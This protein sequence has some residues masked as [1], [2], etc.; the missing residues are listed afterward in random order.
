MTEVKIPYWLDE[1]EILF[2]ES[3]IEKIGSGVYDTDCIIAFISSSSVKSNWVRKELQ[4]AMTREIEENKLRVIPIIIDDCEIPSYLRD[5]LY[6]DLRDEKRLQKEF[7]RIVRSIHN[8]TRI[9]IANSDFGSKVVLSPQ[10]LNIEKRFSRKIVGLLLGLPIPIVMLG[11]LSLI[12]V[13]QLRLW[14]VLTAI[15]FA[16]ASAF[17]LIGYGSYKLAFK[18]DKTLLHEFSNEWSKKKYY[19]PFTGSHL[20]VYRKYKHNDHLARAS[21]YE[22]IGEVIMIVLAVALLFTIPYLFEN[23]ASSDKS[24]GA[25]WLG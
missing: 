19:F 14:A 4:L 9:S 7:K 20:R 23:Y 12:P 10:Q 17:L 8:N 18:N 5:K 21:K 6:A 2:G 13:I 1:S 16:S 22:L 3:L 15:S 11:L 25:F 24:V